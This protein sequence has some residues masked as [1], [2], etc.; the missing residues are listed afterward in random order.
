MTY[1]CGIHTGPNESLEAAQYNKIDA[2]IAAAELTASD[3][4]LEIGCGWGAFAIRAASKTGCRVTGL[5]LSK[6]QLAEAAARVEAAGL[7]DR[8]TLLLCDYRCVAPSSC[9]CYCATR[10]PLPSKFTSI[11]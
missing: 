10:R 4:V 7:S 5:T 1:S 9:F 3:H 11:A 8:I 2:I 6:E